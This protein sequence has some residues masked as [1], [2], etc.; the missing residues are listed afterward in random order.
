MREY[1]RQHQDNR[2]QKAV[3]KILN[4]GKE[5]DDSDVLATLE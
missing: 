2:S 3:H 1:Y 5:K 4:V